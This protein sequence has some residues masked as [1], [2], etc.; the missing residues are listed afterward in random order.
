MKS[1]RNDV[2]RMIVLGVVLVVFQLTVIF[3]F[4]SLGVLL[5]G[6]GKNYEVEEVLSTPEGVL[7]L[8]NGGYIKFIEKN[9]HEYAGVVIPNDKLV[10]NKVPG[11]DRE[12]AKMWLAAKDPHAGRRWLDETQEQKRGYTVFCF[13]AMTEEE[14]KKAEKTKKEMSRPLIPQ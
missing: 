7:E 5:Q 8:N 4:F 9:G 1:S 13:R 6:E 2:V 10:G 14:K 12:R 11:L 3:G